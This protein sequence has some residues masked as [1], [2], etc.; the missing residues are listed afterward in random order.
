MTTA[1][2]RRAD[3]SI[4]GVLTG[5]NHRLLNHGSRTPEGVLRLSFAGKTLFAAMTTAEE[6]IFLS[7]PDAA[8]RPSAR[9]EGTPSFPP[10]AARRPSRKAGGYF[11]F[12]SPTLCVDPPARQEGTSPF[13]PRKEQSPLLR[14][15][16]RTC[17][18]LTHPHFPLNLSIPFGWHSLCSSSFRKTL[19]D[20]NEMV[21]RATPPSMFARNA[22]P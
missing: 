20:R 11:I 12:A 15:L 19:H 3:T 16:D 18:H 9:Q 21:V 14:T 5:A 13:A 1:K 22:A 2:A 10:D 6:P 7:L 8:R 17:V 4:A